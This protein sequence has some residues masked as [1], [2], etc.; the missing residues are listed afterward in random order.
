MKRL[1]PVCALLLATACSSTPEVTETT[2]A[3]APDP[4]E[5]LATMMTGSFSSAAQAAADENYFDIRLEMAPIWTSRDDARWLY[6][7]QAAASSLDQPYRQRIYKVTRREDG[8][9]VSAVYELPDPDAAIGAWREPATLDA[10]TPEALILREGCEVGL[11]AEGDG[12]FA[13]A[14][15]EDHCKSTLRG[16]TYATSEVIVTADGIE[17]WDRGYDAE[18]TQVWGAELGA[19]RFVRAD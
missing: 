7:E 19:Y 17:S 16:A 11:L 1:A 5:S 4:L 8:A 13:G 14:T 15:V 3:P 6:V 18:G 9:F 10:L 2:E 12:R